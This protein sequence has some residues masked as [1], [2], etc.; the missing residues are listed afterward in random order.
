MKNRILILS[1]QSSLTMLLVFTE[2]LHLCPQISR[3]KL[4][5]V[6]P[7]KHRC[8][9][10]VFLSQY[11]DISAAGNKMGGLGHSCSINKSSINP[12]C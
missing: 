7:L 4:K 9:K 3:I 8:L 10:D 5:A 12:E 11:T 2:T 1:A 6:E